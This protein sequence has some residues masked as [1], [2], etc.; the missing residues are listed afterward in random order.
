[1]RAHPFVYFFL[2]LFTGLPLQTERERGRQKNLKK[3]VHKLGIP[4][5]VMIL[6]NYVCEL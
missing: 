5:F 4:A 6:L 3:R 1:M 2:L